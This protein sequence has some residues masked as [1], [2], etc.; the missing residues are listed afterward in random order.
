MDAHDDFV[1]VDIDVPLHQRHWLCKHIEASSHEVN[2]EDLVV[3]NNTEYSFVVA[4]ALLW[5]KLN[6]NPAL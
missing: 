2:V 3:S 4:L 6:N 1:P 5:I